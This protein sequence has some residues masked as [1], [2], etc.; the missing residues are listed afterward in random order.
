MC[1]GQ[2]NFCENLCRLNRILSPQQ[3]AQ[4][5]LRHVAGSKFCRRDKNFHKKFSCTHEA[6]CRRDVLLQLV[7]R[8]VYTEWSVANLS[9]SV[10]TSS[11]FSVRV[12]SY[13]VPWAR[14]GSRRRGPWKWGPKHTGVSLIK[15]K[16]NCSEKFKIT[17]MLQVHIC[18]LAFDGHVGN[19]L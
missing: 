13:S 16:Y 4:F 17:I 1:T 15:T 14:D 2:E 10:F 3:V 18:L 9:H 12:L 11:S 7:V 5:F 8:P 6:I 19:G